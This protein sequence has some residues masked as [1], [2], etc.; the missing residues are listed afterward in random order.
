MNLEKNIIDDIDY[1]K[2]EKKVFNGEGYMF[3]KKD[4]K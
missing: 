3:K 1:E 2:E 4:G